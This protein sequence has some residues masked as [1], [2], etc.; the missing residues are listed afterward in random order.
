VDVHEF[1]DRL[2][3]RGYEYGPVFQG[4][5]AGWVRGPELFAE[6]TLPEQADP[7]GFAI[8]PALFDAAL[9]TVL[10]A[11]DTTRGEGAGGS[12]VVPF[13]W[14]RVILHASGAT[15]VRVRVRAETSGISVELADPSGAPVL[16]VGSLVSRPIPL[17]QL[18]T[19]NNPHRDALFALDWQTLPDLGTQPV[20]QSP[21]RPGPR[22][23]GCWKWSKPS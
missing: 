8:H 1:Y 4:L 20:Y 3:E 19:G 17:D 18:T 5:T 2:T 14:N 6:I 13:V 7:S 10:L 15:V 12:V 11:P 22:S 21:N 23:P 9:H 16:S